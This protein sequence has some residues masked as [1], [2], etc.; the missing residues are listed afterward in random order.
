MGFGFPAGGLSLLATL[1]VSSAPKALEEKKR[2]GSAYFGV[3]QNG[4]VTEE[5]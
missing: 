5:V 4:E 3:A 2:C 1:R